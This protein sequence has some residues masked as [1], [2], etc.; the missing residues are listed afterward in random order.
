MSIGVEIG[1]RFVLVRVHRDATGTLITFICLVLQVL[2][3]VIAVSY[4]SK[5]LVALMALI[6]EH[7]PNSALKR[8]ALGRK[9]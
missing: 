5:S 8:P 7:T 3:T 1:R 6:L 4:P 2:I 9:I